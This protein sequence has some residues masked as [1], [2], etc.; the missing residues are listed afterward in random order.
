MVELSPEEVQ[1]TMKERVGRQRKPAV[2]MSG[3]DNALTLLRPWLILVPQELCR[4]VGDQSPLKQIINVILADRQAD[5]FTLDPARR[6][7][8][9]RRRS[10]PAGL[11]PFR[12]RRRLLRTLQRHRLLLPHGSES[13]SSGAT[14]PRAEAGATE[15]SEE[16]EEE[17]GRTIQKPRSAPY[18]RSLLSD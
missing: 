6:Q 1:E 12:L 3:E 18:I 8:G 13:S 5:P 17:W 2:N 15:K 9:P 16:E 7:A 11:L 14:T 10:A 4:F